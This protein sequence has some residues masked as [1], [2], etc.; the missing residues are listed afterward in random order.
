MVVNGA[1]F[2]HCYFTTG[3][4]A[5][6]GHWIMGSAGPNVVEK[7]VN[8]P[9]MFSASP[10]GKWPLY[11]VVSFASVETLCSGS[12]KLGTARGGA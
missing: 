2:H 4:T 6:G 1:A 9:D 8:R 12:W 5:P 10:N 7:I 3:V 11:S